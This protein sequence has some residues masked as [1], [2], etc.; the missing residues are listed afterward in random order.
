[1]A[2]YAFLDE[3]NIVTEVIVGVDETELIEGKTPEAWYAEFRGQR[4]IRTSFNGNIRKNY[5][6]PGYK[7]D[8]NL[9][10][11][12][13]PQPYESWTLNEETARWDAP[14]PYPQ[15]GKSYV[16]DE[17]SKSWT[18]VILNTPSPEELPIAD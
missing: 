14:T 16:W 5:A 17:E 4:C 2:H 6:A 8:E 10:A 7:Y 18:E 13:S 12:I 11:F 15:D 1:M 9:D 3:N